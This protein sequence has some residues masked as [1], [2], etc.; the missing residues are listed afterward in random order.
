M[1]GVGDLCPGKRVDAE[2]EQVDVGDEARQASRGYSQ[3]W[4]TGE[5]PTVTL[6]HPRS[7]LSASVRK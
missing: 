3:G 4:A 6:Q 5:K 1:A 2:M 7:S